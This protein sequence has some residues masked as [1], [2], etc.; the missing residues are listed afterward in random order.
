[1]IRSAE[2][3][4]NEKCYPFIQLDM[5]NPDQWRLYWGQVDGDVPHS[6]GSK[7]SNRDE[8]ERVKEAIGDDKHARF[9]K[10]INL[11]DDLYD[12]RGA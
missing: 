4:F 7:S 2:V 5:E 12:V 10:H 11:S 9:D 6:I 3:R 1:M 8:F